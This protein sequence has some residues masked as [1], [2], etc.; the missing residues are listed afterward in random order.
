[1]I[2]G[3]EKLLRLVERLAEIAAGLA[4]GFMLEGT[5]MMMAADE[6]SLPLLVKPHMR[7]WHGATRFRGFGRN[8]VACRAVNKQFCGST[9]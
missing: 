2:A 9:I 5:Q 1:M 4:L 6:E 8:C 3:R 7:A